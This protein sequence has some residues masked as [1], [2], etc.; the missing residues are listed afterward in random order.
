VGERP[1]D[2]HKID[3]E[4]APD[5]DMAG[6]EDVTVPE[7]DDASRNGMGTPAS[8]DPEQM[9]DVSPDELGGTGGPD[10]GGAG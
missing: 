3:S 4:P 10:A 7:N 5:V 1:D 6:S 9:A 2:E 8:S